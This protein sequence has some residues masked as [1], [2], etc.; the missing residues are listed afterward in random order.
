MLGLLRS[1]RLLV[2][3]V[4]VILRLV[5]RPAALL[6]F[7]LLGLRPVHLLRLWLIHNNGYPTS[8]LKYL[9]P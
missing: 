2:L 6:S 1:I 4:A 7:F 3:L 8:K 5:L 9:N